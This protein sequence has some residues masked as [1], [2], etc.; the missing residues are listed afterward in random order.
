MISRSGLTNNPLTVSYSASGSAVSGTDYQALSSTVIIPAG[1]DSV[2]V[3]V[4]PLVDSDFNE[5]TE[6]VT[7][8]LSTQPAYDVSDVGGSATISIVE[9]AAPVAATVYTQVLPERFSTR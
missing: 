7:L 2:T 4:V 3:S 8:T 6:A 1:A 9:D 5:G